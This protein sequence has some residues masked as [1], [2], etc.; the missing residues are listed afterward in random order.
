MSES[1]QVRLPEVDELLPDAPE[2][3]ARSAG[4][5][6]ARL[7]GAAV[8]NCLSSS[9]LPCMR[10]FRQTPGTLRTEVSGELT[11]RWACAS[12]TPAAARSS[13]PPARRLPRHR[14]C[15]APEVSCQ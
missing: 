6:A 12:S 1:R 14:A 2:P 5:N 15:R 11:S 8:A 10:K 9:L 7:I 3:P 13:S 4:P